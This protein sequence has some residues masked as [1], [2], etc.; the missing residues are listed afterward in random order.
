MVLN[1]NTSSSLLLSDCCSASFFTE[2]IPLPSCL[3]PEWQYLNPQMALQYQYPSWNKPKLSPPR[4][5]L[6]TWWERRQRT[7]LHSWVLD[8]AL[9]TP[10]ETGTWSLSV[11]SCLFRSV[12]FSFC[13]FVFVF[14][15]LRLFGHIQTS[16][17]FGLN[18]QSRITQFSCLHTG[19][20]S[21]AI[22]A[23]WLHSV[24]LARSSSAVTSAHPSHTWVNIP[25]TSQRRPVSV[26]R[27]GQVPPVAPQR[28]LTGLGYDWATRP[29]S[30][31]VRRK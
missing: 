22:L 23:S 16:T 11:C 21:K 19:I 3:S 10:P 28:R 13:L 25:I 20:V 6:S 5:V 24:Y 31:E 8:A 2:G 9:I 14:V 1:L 27:P 30:A 15:S 12:F 18:T 4:L 17:V 7:F 29:G 26:Q